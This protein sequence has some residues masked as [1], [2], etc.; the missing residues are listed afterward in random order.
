MPIRSWTD[1]DEGRGVVI[2]DLFTF[3]DFRDERRVDDGSAL[4]RRAVTF[5]GHDPLGQRLGCQEFDLEHRVEAALVAEER[6]DVLGAYLGITSLLRSHVRAMSVRMTLPLKGY[7]RR[8]LRRR[9]RALG[10]LSTGDAGDGE[11]SPAVRD[12]AT[13]CVALVPA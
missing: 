2:G 7:E 8:R 5:G 10:R 13:F 4:S 1:V 12:E 6:G 3:V 11:D 9:A